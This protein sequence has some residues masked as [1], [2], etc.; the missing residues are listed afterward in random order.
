MSDAKD[1]ITEVNKMAM[2]KFGGVNDMPRGWTTRS[3]LN[4]KIY[5]TWSD[6]LRRCYDIN[7]Q[8]TTAGRT[9]ASCVVC[10]RWKYLSNFVEDVKHLDGYKAWATSDKWSIDKDLHYHPEIKRYSPETCSFISIS[11][12]VK[13]MHHRLGN[14]PEAA[15]E[16]NRTWYVLYNA[17]GHKVFRTGR[18]AAMFLGISQGW[19]SRLCKEGRK[20]KGYTIVKVGNSQKGG[21][22]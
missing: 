18:E 3:K 17:D 22:A 21:A 5:K 14:T 4:R 12:N 6:M 7:R 8:K 20:V 2:T 15:A 19:M 13:E 10:D 11:D 1:T 16:A 9:Y